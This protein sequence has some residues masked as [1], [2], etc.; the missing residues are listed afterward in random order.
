MSAADEQAPGPTLS[1][2]TDSS[3]FERLIE[4]TF[5]SD[6]LQEMWF[7]RDRA[8]DVMHSTVDAFGYDLVLQSQDLIRHVQLKAVRRGGGTSSWNLSTKLMDLPS[9]CAIVIEWVPNDHRRV[10]LSYRFF[11]TTPGQAIPDLGGRVAK[12]SRANAEGVKGLRPG[13]RVVTKSRFAPMAN[14]ADLAD[15]LF[16]SHGGR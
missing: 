16:G 3:A 5:L 9:A 11:G 2:I 12:H 4:V 6:L 15:H 14:I 1:E 8:L 7:A 13:L 10:D